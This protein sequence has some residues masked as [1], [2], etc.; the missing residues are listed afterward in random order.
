[1]HALCPVLQ[2]PL[3]Y[4]LSTAISFLRRLCHTSNALAQEFLRAVISHTGSAV[5][6]AGARYLNL[7]GW[8]FSANGIVSLDGYLL[9]V[10]FDSLKDMRSIF[11][12]PGRITFKDK[13][14]TAKELIL[15]H[16]I[17]PF[18]IELFR[19]CLSQNLSKLL[20]IDRRLPGCSCQSHP[21]CGQLDTH[22]HRQLECQNFL[23]V[24]QRHPHF[25]SF[26]Q[27]CPAK[28]WLP[29][30][31]S[32]PDIEVLQQLMDHRRQSSDH[33]SAWIRMSCFS[34]LMALQIL[35]LAQRHVELL[36]PSFS[37]PLQPRH[38]N[39]LPLK[40]SMSLVDS[41]YLVLNWRLSHGFCNTLPLLIG[42]NRL[43]S[44]PTPKM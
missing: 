27:R 24:R 11:D 30:P 8:S 21:H 28:L 22:S 39:I 4:V 5:G 9:S 1:M 10:R 40:F 32:F 14:P 33:S 2:D 25:I 15:I 44:Q 16:S 29:L 23:A 6:P 34:I 18:C 42:L 38:P 20:T 26:L 36:G 31:W 35:L 37:L 3:L 17:F 19:A 43:L 13:F 7:V 41:P 12:Q